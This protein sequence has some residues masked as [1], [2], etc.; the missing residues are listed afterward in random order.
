MSKDKRINLTERI[1]AK[2]IKQIKKRFVISAIK[3]V[4]P[5][6]ITKFLKS[7]ILQN[8]SILKRKMSDTL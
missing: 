5:A 8:E 1:V 4:G 6:T 2:I 7:A 3:P